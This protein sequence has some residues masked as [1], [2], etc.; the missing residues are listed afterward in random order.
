MLLKKNFAFLACI[1]IIVLSLAIVGCK[2]QKAQTEPQPGQ[3]QGPGDE[4]SEQQGPPAPLQQAGQGDNVFTGDGAALN[5]GGKMPEELAP[6][7]HENL[8]RL[9]TLYV[10]VAPETVING[11]EALEAG[12]KILQEKQVKNILICASMWEKEPS[13]HYT[14]MGGGDYTLDGHAYTIFALI[15]SD[16]FDG[17]PGKELA[18]ILGGRE[19]DNVIWHP[20]PGLKIDDDGL[21]ANAE[22]QSGPY[23]QLIN[24]KRFY[25]L[26]DGCPAR[27]RTHIQHGVQ[28]G[29][30]EQP[31][32]QP[33][34]VEQ[35]QE[36]PEPVEQP[37]E[38]P[39]PVE[40]PQEQPEPVEQPQEQPEPVEQPQEQP[41]PE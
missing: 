4:G 14:I 12:V 7:M 11:I 36:Q 30:G 26:L 25:Q 34:P 23:K 2:Q 8:E 21:A 16:G 35:P 39:E 6:F 37:Q 9:N 10:G 28:A 41:E 19:N 33:E 3:Q 1:T 20:K 15:I 29:S 5:D 13:G 38:Q 18:F 40:Q 32:E 22:K 24:P 27:E 31:Q 17:E